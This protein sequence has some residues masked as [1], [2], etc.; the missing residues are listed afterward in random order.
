MKLTIQSQYHINIHA[1]YDGYVAIEQIDGTNEN[2]SVFI[3]ANNIDML[4][5][6]LQEAKTVAQE[7]QKQYLQ[8]KNDYL[9]YQEK[10]K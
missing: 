1:M 9:I 10:N 4:C 3:A 2:S 8:K 5:Q 6:M 7:K